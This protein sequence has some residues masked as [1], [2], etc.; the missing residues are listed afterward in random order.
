MKK[1]LLGIVLLLAIASTACAGGFANTTTL[2]AG[3]NLVQF[4]DPAISPGY[5]GCV[6]GAI[7]LSPHL[8]GVG[9]VNYGFRNHYWRSTAG[10]RVTATDV[11]NMDFSVGLGIQY[12]SCNWLGLE[13]NE[14]CPDVAVGFRPLPNDLPGLTLTG[15]GWY[16]LDTKKAAADVGI[17]WAFNL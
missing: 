8:S 15:L 10:V 5:E 12:H 6:N 7:S 3:A 4:D 17:R 13:P 16:G 2:A 9:S 1:I 11:D 14:W